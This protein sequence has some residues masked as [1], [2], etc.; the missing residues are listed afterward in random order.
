MNTY[1]LIQRYRQELGYPADQT[2]EIVA[3][4]VDRLELQQEFKRFLRAET[5]VDL[6]P[7]EDSFSYNG[8]LF[9]VFAFHAGLDETAGPAERI[10]VD[11]EVLALEAFSTLLSSTEY[12]RFVIVQFNPD[13]SSSRELLRYDRGTSGQQW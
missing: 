4:F 8:K 5:G 1:A 10:D 11:T 13:G 3:T 6:D 9:A 7:D 12:G 2:I